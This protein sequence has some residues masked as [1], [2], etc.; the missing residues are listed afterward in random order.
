MDA[1]SRDRLGLCM[2]R[3]F[4]GGPVSKTPHSQCRG[5]GSIPGQGTRSH[6]PQTRSQVLQLRVR[7]TQLKRS[8]MSQ[9][10]PSTAK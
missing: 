10:T 4:P 7:V 6:M 3:D 9:L 5:P 1:H 2:N 8:H